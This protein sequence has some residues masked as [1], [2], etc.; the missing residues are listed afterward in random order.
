[1]LLIFQLFLACLEAIQAEHIL[2][3]VDQH[4]LFSNIRE[5]CETNIRFWTMHMYP[6]V[7][8][9]SIQSLNP[10]NPVRV[11]NFFACFAVVGVVRYLIESHSLT[12][13]DAFDRV[14]IYS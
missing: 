9:Y 6:M 8:I 13:D 2:T 5:I 3:D 4:K 12:Y 14:H 11:W 10:I 1:M 7:S